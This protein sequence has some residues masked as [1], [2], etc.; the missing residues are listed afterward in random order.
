MVSAQSNDETW[1][2]VSSTVNGANAT[3]TA[4]PADFCEFEGWYAGNVLINTEPSIDVSVCENVEL[5]AQFSKLPYQVTYTTD[6]AWGEYLSGSVT[7]KNVSGETLNN[8]SASFNYDGEIT[9]L[10]GAPLVSQ[11]DGVVVVSAPA[12]DKELADGEELT[13]GFNAM[14]ADPEAITA[15]WNVVITG[16]EAA[17]A[18][19]S[20]YSV[21][22]VKNSE[23][24]TGYI[25]TIEITNTSDAVLE[26]WTVEFDFAD[27]VVSAWGGVI[28]GAE[29]NHYV[30]TNGGYN[31]DIAP[32]D[33]VTVGFIGVPANGEEASTAEFENIVLTSLR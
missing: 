29:N 9:A 4:T 30:I 26:S 8:W 11:V 24:S 28:A 15:P 17:V 6:S 19:G 21:A 27:E 32:G 14:V 10:W 18:D 23:W 33:T 22:V 13:F 2:T 12:W 5:T 3:F 1:G 20:E 25:S 31:A 7:V 16:K